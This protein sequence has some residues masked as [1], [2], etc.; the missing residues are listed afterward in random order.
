MKFRVT[1]FVIVVGT[2]L[3]PAIP[4]SAQER[5]RGNSQGGR[6]RVTMTDGIV[7]SVAFSPDGK[8]LASGGDNLTVELRD[9]QSGDTQATF[10]GHTDWVWSLAYTRDG[11]TLASVSKDTTIRIWDVRAGKERATLAGHTDW[12]CAVAFSADGRTLAEGNTNRSIRLWDVQTAKVRTTLKWSQD[13]LSEQ[14]APLP[15]QEQ[16]VAFSPDGNTLASLNI[17]KT[18]HLWNATT[19]K[20]EAKFNEGLRGG[21]TCLAFSSDGQTRAST[22]GGR[23]MVWKDLINGKEPQYLLEEQVLSIAFSPDGRRL[24]S[25]NQ[26]GP[27]R[28]W[29]VTSGELQTELRGH[30]GP[31]WSVAYSPDG[32]TLASGGNDKTIR[33]WEGGIRD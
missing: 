28:I 24:A 20:V 9:I 15:R 25:A 31:V 3:T 6:N 13:W 21:T 23:V 1:F 10:K 16:A 12:E 27:I 19:G 2:K 11:N 22:A 7:R 4:L 17:D 5:A 8:T 26:T 30:R 18:I 14:V 32:K 33:L 29:N